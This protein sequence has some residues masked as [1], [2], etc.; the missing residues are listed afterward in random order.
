MGLLR[1]EVSEGIG[2][3]ILNR[4]EK[5]NAFNSELLTQMLNAIEAMDRD[6]SVGVVAIT[7]EGRL[8]SAG[9]DLGEL[10][11]AET[12]DEA[13]K[14]FRLLGR[15]VAKLIML[16]KPVVI[17]YNGDAYGGGAELIWAADIVVAVRTAKLV[18]AEAKWGLIPPG[19]STIGAIALG[20]LRA[21]YLAMTSGGLTAEEAHKL[22]LVHVLVD[23]PQQ[24][25]GKIREVV[26]RVRENSPQA[27]VSIK[28]MIR[29]TKLTALLELGVSE[30]ERLAR[31]NEAKKAAEAFR[32]K[33]K[34]KYKWPH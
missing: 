15:V 12:P 9:A 14:L 13:A 26:D 1:T 11:V 2:W 10:A 25:R 8:F 22:G 18:W 32:N 17:G 31:T 5:L 33:Q 23:E 21:S 16:D 34:P 24:L 3:I 28:R 30:L 7:G 6:S 29:Y 19:L 4:P 20:P 27:I